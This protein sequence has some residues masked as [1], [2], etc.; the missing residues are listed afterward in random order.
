MLLSLNLKYSRRNSA[1]FVGLLRLLGNPI[2]CFS[3]K[4]VGVF[5]VICFLVATEL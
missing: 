1:E 2:L 3:R 4:V 5:F